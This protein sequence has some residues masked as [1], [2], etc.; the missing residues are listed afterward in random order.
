[1][2]LQTQGFL[3]TVMSYTLNIL[4]VLWVTGE[5]HEN[6]STVRDTTVS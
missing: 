2:L 5:S 3:E 1:M 6:F 4:G